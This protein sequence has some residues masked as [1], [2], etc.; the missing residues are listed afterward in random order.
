M[1]VIMM[2]LMM[3]SSR[4]VV[5]SSVQVQESAMEKTRMARNMP[6][7]SR[8]LARFPVYW[9]LGSKRFLKCLAFL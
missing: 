1:S 4:N 3:K 8:V 7:I 2:M 6:P 5:R 9:T